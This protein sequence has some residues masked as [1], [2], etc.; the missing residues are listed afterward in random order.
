MCSHF[1]KVWIA[2]TDP[3]ASSRLRQDSSTGGWT[4]RPTYGGVHGSTGLNAQDKH[5]WFRVVFL[6]TF[7]CQPAQS[8]ARVWQHGDV[9]SHSEHYPCSLRPFAQFEQLVLSFLINPIGAYTADSWV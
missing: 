5:T 8:G 7:R 1:D 2:L 6:F 4:K 3:L 9:P